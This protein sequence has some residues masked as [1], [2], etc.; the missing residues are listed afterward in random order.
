M[1]IFLLTLL[2]CFSI[3]FNAIDNKQNTHTSNGKTY[4][5]FK[6]PVARKYKVLYWYSG[7]HLLYTVAV[8]IWL[9]TMRHPWEKYTPTYITEHHLH[10]SAQYLQRYDKFEIVF[11]LFTSMILYTYI[12][13]SKIVKSIVSI[14]IIFV[15]INV[16]YLLHDYNEPTNQLVFELLTGGFTFLVLWSLLIRQPNFFKMLRLK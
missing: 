13:F 12:I 3:F 16:L 5:V 4:E 9:L 7:L 10:H 2:A 8:S 11:I 1:I 6:F 15:A 14:L